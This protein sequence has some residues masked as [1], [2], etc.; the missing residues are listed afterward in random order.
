M[1]VSQPKNR[2]TI[3]IKPKMI[4]TL[5]TLL[6]ITPLLLN[7][8]TPELVVKHSYDVYK[9][10][11]VDKTIQVKVNKYIESN[12]IN[13]IIS[14]TKILTYGKY[15]GGLFIGTIENGA[16]IGK[17]YNNYQFYDIEKMYTIN[18][19]TYTTLIVEKSINY[20]FYTSLLITGT[21][22]TTLIILIRKDKDETAQL[23]VV[24]TIVSTLV[25]ALTGI[26]F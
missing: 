18:K 17:V 15:K 20:A 10:P 16:L 22:V 9:F 23:L 1:I 25:F 8:I 6:T 7:I 24:P 11:R 2:N 3:S 19:E 14:S 13:N 21:L 5:L 12:N 4:T 26:V